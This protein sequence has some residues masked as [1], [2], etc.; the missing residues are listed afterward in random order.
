[1]GPQPRAVVEQII[2]EAARSD[3]APTI[4]AHILFE[5]STLAQFD[6]RFDEARR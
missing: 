1:V 5:R 6:G 2:E 3:E 4:A